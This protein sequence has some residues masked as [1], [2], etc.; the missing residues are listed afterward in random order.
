M[1]LSAT[2]MIGLILM[3]DIKR[4]SHWKVML[5]NFPIRSKFVLEKQFPFLQGKLNETVAAGI[6][7][8]FLAFTIQSVFFTSNARARQ[9]PSSSTAATS[10]SSPIASSSAA[11]A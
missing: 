5:K 4:K 11:S 2:M 3:E 10:G 6:V 8:L 9:P 1:L 7:G